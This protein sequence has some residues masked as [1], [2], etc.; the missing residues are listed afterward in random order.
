[1]D[2]V[3]T[4]LVLLLVVALSGAVVRVLPVKLPL[5]LLQIVLGALLAQPFGMHVEF[6]HELFFLLFIPPLLFADGWRIPKREFFLL[7]GPI[8]ALAIGLVFFTILG[9]GYFVHWMIPTVPLAVAFA[10]AAVLSPTDAVAVSSIT[11]EATIP[12]RLMHILSGEALLNDASGLVVLQFAIAA[13]I[14]GKFSLAEAAGDFAV[15]ALG[16]VATGAF[17]GYAFG[18]FRRRLVRWSD[19]VDPA[20]Q[21]ALLLLL[22]FAAYLLAERFHVSG[23]LA[24]VAAGMMM[25]YTDVLK[26]GYVATR[27]QNGAVWSM[28]EFTFNGLIFLLLGLQLPGIIDGA[29]NDLVQA[30]GG[31][32][33]HL[34]AYVVAITLA[35]VVLRFIWVWVSL[36]FM[37][38]R[39]LHRGEKRP[40]V[41]TRLVWTTALA[42]VR[43]AITMAGV[44]SLPLMKGD[45]VP[46]P[47][48]EL[49][50]FL[51]TG[52]ILCTLLFGA[53]GLPLSV[54]GLK[55]PG[56]DP[57]VREERKA[58]ALAAE[59]ALRG[60]AG[61]QQRVEGSGD[62]NAVALASRVAARVMADYQ[63]RLEAAGE[64]G[65]VP[66]KA[67]AEAGTERVMRLAALRAERRELY[68]L[69]RSHEINDETLQTLLRE[70]DLAEA[71]LTGLHSG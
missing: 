11:G 69:R 44:L 61:E 7:R 68:A 31:R 42:G 37:L 66:E 19:E 47:V 57:R 3:I 51:A 18:V 59:A 12:P 20:S 13:E 9:I 15:M 54:K 55:I 33:W 65:D 35:L 16:G 56:E 49:M 21:V 71:A 28:V 43:G 6:D 29:K 22:P 25:N 45:A 60:I 41:G 30:G 40:K 14:T 26:G 17:I 70:V 36:R 63:Q 64:E 50:I 67:R 53:I 62:E 38:M 34:P 58:R 46:F 52:V 32:M 23:I 1:M 24:A 39:A 2:L 5:P 4:I 27:M 48:R 8:L 10:L